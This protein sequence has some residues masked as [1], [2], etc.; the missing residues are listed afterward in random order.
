MIGRV[1]TFVHKH[2]EYISPAVFLFG[3]VIDNLT[4]TRIDVLFDNIILASY[5]GIATFSIFALSAITSSRWRFRYSDRVVYFLPFVLQFAFGGLFSG[6][7]V[8][9]SRSS[10]LATSWLF[11][12]VLV[13]FLVANEFFEGFKRHYQRLTFQLSI[14][15]LGIFSYTIFLVPVIIKQIGTLVFL[16]S[17]VVA[18]GVFLLLFVVLTRLAPERARRSRRSVTLSVVSMYVVVHIL[19]FAHIIPPIPLSLKDIGVYHHVTRTPDG[20]T[21]HEEERPWF[22]VLT[23]HDRT[24]AWTGEPVYVFA[25]VFAPTNLTATVYHKWQF[26]SARGWETRSR[27]PIKLSGGRDGGYRGYTFKGSLEEGAWRVRIVTDNGGIVG[28]AKFEIERVST[29]PELVIIT[30]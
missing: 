11:L 1:K 7:F 4:L 15:F 28:Q 16:A 25:S 24:I 6:F 29:I 2:A 17:G 23:K 14:L 27:I 3:F 8:F 12:V 18:L 5:V 20:Y 9:Y 10:S 22:D 30:K 19:Y 26:K 13:A 21:V